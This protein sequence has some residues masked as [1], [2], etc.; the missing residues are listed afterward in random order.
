MTREHEKVISWVAA[1]PTKPTSAEA[2]KFLL[3]W[4]E[5]SIVR[6]LSLSVNH[7]NRG[8]WM[9]YDEVRH[10]MA[11][12]RTRENLAVKIWHLERQEARKLTRKERSGHV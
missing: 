10:C 11:C 1:H 8:Q 12:A 5:D 6:G 2:D 4:V 7:D 9:A 3:D